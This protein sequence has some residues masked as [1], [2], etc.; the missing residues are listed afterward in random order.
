MLRRDRST[1]Y[2]SFASSSNGSEVRFAEG[3]G[4]ARAG[5]GGTDSELAMTIPDDTLSVFLGLV[6]SVEGVT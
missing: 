1:P 3:T 2:T 5:V 6:I 4:G